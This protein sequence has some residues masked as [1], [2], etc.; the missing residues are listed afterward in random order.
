[1][2]S[3]DSTGIETGP[4][5]FACSG[6]L[7]RQATPHAP[8][9]IGVTAVDRRRA[10]REFRSARAERNDR[11]VVTTEHS[12]VQRPVGA[13]SSRPQQD[14]RAVMVAHVEVSIEGLRRCGR[15]LEGCRAQQCSCGLRCSGPLHRAA[16]WGRRRPAVL[17]IASRL[18]I[19]S[20]PVGCF[21]R[22]LPAMQV[23]HVTEVPEPS[24]GTRARRFVP[25]SADFACPFDTFA[26]CGEAAAR[27]GWAG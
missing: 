9:P 2:W 24:R 7:S 22:R 26:S 25:R 3:D 10:H 13:G 21:D 16:A 4:L 15:S 18:P 6:E 12:D 27:R 1:M 19:T 14:R 11:W 17:L 23:G 8:S 5:L 20:S